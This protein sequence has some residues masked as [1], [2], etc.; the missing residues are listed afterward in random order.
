LSAG[1]NPHYLNPEH[2][3]F[4]RWKR[5]REISI[6]RGKFVKKILSQFKNP[7]N[8]KI[9]DV[10]SGFGGT[11]QNFV[12]SGNKIFSV[13][14]DEFKLKQ[15]PDVEGVFKILADVYTLSTNEKFDI[16][17][18][19]DLI[20]HLKNP[21]EFLSYILNFLKDDG[22]IYL[23]T[24]NRLSIINFFSDPHW[25][26]P[27]ISIMKR[28]TLKKFFIPIFR[29]SEIHRNDIAELLSLKKLR[30]VFTNYGLDYQLK[31]TTAVRTLF[32]N[33]EQ[34]IWSDFH[35]SLL[36]ILMK[37]NLKRF[38]ISLANDK[39][40]FLNTFITPTFYFVLRRK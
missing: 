24:P 2:P 5:S 40:K 4:N 36:K 39:P 14:I 37:L 7:V 26:F 12:S 18:L 33:P 31:T 3:N 6:E 17:I 34:I 8:L 20:E 30:K 15:Q 29:K 32:E 27:F 25:G 16:I 23:S 19:Q 10:G 9:L 13:E 35:L 21:E 28:K 22:I 1:N 11:V 38:F